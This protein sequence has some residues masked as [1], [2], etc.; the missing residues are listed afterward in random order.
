AGDPCTGSVTVSFPSRCAAPL[1]AA[2]ERGLKPKD[3]FR[4]CDNCPEM[5]VV[6]AGSFTMGSPK[7]EKGHRKN[8]DP[9]R[10]VTI[11][12]PFAVG[13]LHV[14]VDQFAAFVRVTGHEPSS[15]CLTQKGANHSWHDL[16]FAQEGSHPVVCLSWD[17]VKV[18][19]D[20]L[21][22]RTGK[23]Y[24]LLSEAE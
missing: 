18:Y 8:E 14:T 20:W 9:Q 3:S 19:V 7:S 4:E 24:R 11:S 10:V 16:G 12:R 15:S 2:Q 5:V 23:P 13:K 1:T 22:K 6:P 21:A 17:D